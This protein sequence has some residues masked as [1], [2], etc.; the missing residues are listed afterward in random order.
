VYSMDYKV[1]KLDWSPDF[2]QMN[3]RKKT[4]ALSKNPMSHYT[5]ITSTI[6][7]RVIIINTSSQV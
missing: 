3:C 5:V 1:A 4:A 2:H 7:I 6:I